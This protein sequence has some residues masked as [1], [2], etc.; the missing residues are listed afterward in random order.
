MRL[1]SEDDFATEAPPLSHALGSLRAGSA[2]RDATMLMDAQGPDMTQVLRWRGVASLPQRPGILGDLR[3]VFTAVR[4][5]AATR[6]RLADIRGRLETQREARARLVL[7][8]ARAAVADAAVTAEV[9]VETRARVAEIEAARDRHALD[10]AAARAVLADLIEA[11][12]TAELAAAAEIAQIEEEVA[13]V[14]ATLVPFE[15]AEEDLRR[16]ARAV[17]A[18]VKRQDRRIR[19]L[20]KKLAQSNPEQAGALQAELAAARA[21]REGEVQKTPQIEAARD[22]LAPQMDELRVRLNELDSELAAAEERAKAA[23]A[24]GDE[25]AEA[26]ARC[27]QAEEAGQRAIVEIRER[28]AGLGEELCLSRPENASL[29]PHLAAIDRCDS[30]IGALERNTIE[31]RHVLQAIDRG[32]VLRGSLLLAALALALAALGW[33]ALGLL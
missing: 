10:G 14:Q 27:E 32:A 30:S 7:A 19:G 17:Q 3:Y 15:V 13:E 22:E 24:G 6:R 2:E 33:L 26:R 9:V 31:G 5:M 25:V 16:H 8:L 23:A 20:E 4:G 21:E 1:G 11:Q 29:A 28:L 12:E 18:T